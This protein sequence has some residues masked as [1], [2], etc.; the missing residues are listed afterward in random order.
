MYVNVLFYVC[1]LPTVI[2][3]FFLG[4]KTEN[5]VVQ[6]WLSHS[7]VEAAKKGYAA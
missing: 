5:L 1:F 2:D 6:A 4:Q 3:F 7:A